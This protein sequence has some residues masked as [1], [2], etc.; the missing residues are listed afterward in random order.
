[1]KWHTWVEGKG[2]RG[3]T[4]AAHSNND[5]PDPN[6][7]DQKYRWRWAEARCFSKWN[8]WNIESTWQWRK[9]HSPERWNSCTSHVSGS[10][11]VGPVRDSVSLSPHTH[12]DWE[13]LHVN[14]GSLSSDRLPQTLKY[15]PWSSTPPPQPSTSKWFRFKSLNKHHTV[16]LWLHMLSP[17]HMGLLVCDCNLYS[18]MCFM[19]QNNVVMYLCYLA[20]AK[21]WEIAYIKYSS[22]KKTQKHLKSF[23]P[24]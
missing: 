12:R 5:P 19:R 7:A 22:L 18:R 2:A 15:E 11:G 21:A 17:L 4:E 3:R 20:E 8:E 14:K 6:S 23:S 24:N 9:V 10:E 13:Q 16:H 1:M